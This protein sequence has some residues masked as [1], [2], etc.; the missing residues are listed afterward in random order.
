[1][2]GEPVMI[3]GELLEYTRLQELD[4]PNADTNSP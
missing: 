4:D 2:G 1:M 3:I